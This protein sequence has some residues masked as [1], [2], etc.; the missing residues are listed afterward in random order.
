VALHLLSLTE[1]AAR[2][3]SLLTRLAPAARD[4]LAAQAQ[5]HAAGLGLRRGKEPIPLV[6]SPVSLPRAELAQLGRA[7][8]LIV[9]ALV[10]VAREVIDRSPDKQKLLF[11]HLSPLEL[12]ALATRSREAEELLIARV[13]WFVDAGG[14][15]RALEVNATIPAMPVY[16]DAAVA[17]WLSAT[18]PGQA[19]TLAAKNPGNAAWLVDNLLAA[20][21]NAG[22]GGRG[23]PWPR[24]LKV[25]LLHRDGDPQ[26][27]ELDVLVGLLKGRGAQARTA[28][29]EDVVLDADPAGVIYRH[30][31]ARYVATGTPLGRAFLD[32]VRYA[33]WNRVD[34]WLETK[35]LFAELSA[36]A[37][38][39]GHLLDPEERAA[40]RAHVPY[41]RLLDEV[42]DAQLAGGDRFVL[43][44]SHDYGGK[45]VVIGRERGAEA[46]R[47]VLAEARR[48]PPGTWVVQ[49]LV[50]APPLARWY[51]ARA[52][53]GGIFARRA[54]LHLD[55]STFATLLEGAPHGNSVCR[56]ALGIVVNIAGGGGVAPLFA[57][58]VLGE[59]LDA[60]DSGVPANQ[61]R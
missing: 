43:K 53:D 7:A 27:P 13:D 9:S 18:A 12:E 38:E 36:H 23:K 28:T 37:D 51:C 29:P 4:A 55:I 35:G 19:G 39:S 40:I 33:I 26:L 31:F 45:S 58:D 47:A 52:A 6:L 22:R 57:D 24:G 15:P 50:D 3:D 17:G 11:S 34:G 20:A 10:K 8:R 54:D 21:K 60:M 56:A 32:P 30:L 5:R 41:T 44:K 59:A 25:Q 46:F 1:A 14:T 42:S 61:I 48:D 16:S 2:A 49:E